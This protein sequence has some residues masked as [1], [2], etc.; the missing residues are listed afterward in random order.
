MIWISKNFEKQNFSESK[1]SSLVFWGTLESVEIKTIKKMENF[2]NQDFDFQKTL[3]VPF[4][5]QKKKFHE[6]L[7][8]EL[9]ILSFCTFESDSSIAF[10]L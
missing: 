3:D 9:L 7:E 2:C 6:E 10:V 5:I 4:G 8:R 1:H